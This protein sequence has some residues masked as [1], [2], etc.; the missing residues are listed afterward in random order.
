M[1]IPFLI[2]SKRVKNQPETLMWVLVQIRR[3]ADV[4]VNRLIFRQIQ[5]CVLIDASTLHPTEGYMQALT[6]T[7]ELIIVL[8]LRPLSPKE[9]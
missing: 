6:H 4:P 2:D 9:Y 3:I 1:T 8:F 7:E 5:F